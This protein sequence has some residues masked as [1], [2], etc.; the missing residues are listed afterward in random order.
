MVSVMPTPNRLLGADGFKFSE[1]DAV[2]FHEAMV[3]L[4]KIFAN[5]NGSIEF[6]GEVLNLSESLKEIMVEKDPLILEVIFMH[7]CME[8][9][10]TC[11]C[12]I[13]E[14]QQKIIISAP[15]IGKLV[16]TFLSALRVASTGEKDML[17][18]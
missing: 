17:F 13:A 5:N 3:D 8:K 18:I 15:G 2:L 14:Y 11:F 7:P 10:L 16:L 4:S 6:N 9:V 1:K 12:D